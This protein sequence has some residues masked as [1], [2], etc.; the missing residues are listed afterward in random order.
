MRHV[1]QEV[2]QQGEP[3]HSQADA[4][5]RQ[6][7]RVSAVRPRFHAEDVAGPA[8]AVSLGTEALPMSGL[9]QGIR[10]QHLAQE[11][12]QSAREGDVV[13]EVKGKF[14]MS[15]IHSDLYLVRIDLLTA[16]VI[17][18][19]KCNTQMILK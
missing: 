7:A 4:H 10:V 2:R 17:F 12:S 19:N 16:I 14:T 1:R 18:R 3:E 6:A 9:R 5:G 11:A 15:L 13:A 8:P